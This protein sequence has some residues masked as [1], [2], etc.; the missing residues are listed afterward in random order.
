[1]R[2]HEQ[3]KKIR[4][5]RHLSLKAVAGQAHCSVSHLRSI[6]RGDITPGIEVVQRLAKTYGTSLH[7]L[8]K[9]VSVHDHPPRGLPIDL[10]DL[11]RDPLYGPQVT[12][13]LVRIL[14]RTQLPGQ[15]P[16]AREEWLM[17]LTHLKNVLAPVSDTDPPGHSHVVLA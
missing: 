14:C 12:P 15:R 6:E 13:E 8:L 1:M 11:L 3:L 9:H 7:E 5:K 17:T 4:T 2:L 10:A 16:R